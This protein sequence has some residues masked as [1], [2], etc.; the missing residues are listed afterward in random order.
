MKKQIRDI[1]LRHMVVSLELPENHSGLRLRVGPNGEIN[2]LGVDD[3]EVK[4]TKS[5]RSVFEKKPNKNKQ[6][7]QMEMVGESVSIGGLKELHE[8]D[9]FFVLDTSTKILADTRIS[10]TFLIRI[11][12]HKEPN[13]YRA[14]NKDKDAFFFEF[15]GIPEQENPEMFAVLKLAYDVLRTEALRPDNI[16]GI[17]TD[18][19]MINHSAISNQLT[20]IYKDKL[21]PKYFKLIYA[22]DQGGDAINQLIGLC[23]KQASRKLKEYELGKWGG[24]QLR[25]AEEDSDVLCTCHPVPIKQFDMGLLKESTGS[26]GEIK[27]YA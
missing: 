15:H 4:P 26:I 20:P 19:D 23:D 17:I 14:V 27:F 16:I 3:N 10:I 2:L 7:T 25:P 13:G 8:L 18:S 9:S 5:T 21:L 1:S 11:K 22:K 12:L 24:G 6:L